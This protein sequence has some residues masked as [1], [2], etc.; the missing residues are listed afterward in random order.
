M[1]IYVIAW[2]IVRMGFVGLRSTMRV[3]AL[4]DVL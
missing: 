3:A 4:D 2:G 1:I